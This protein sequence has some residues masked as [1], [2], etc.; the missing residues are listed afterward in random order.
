MYFFVAKI[1]IQI[2]ANIA[3]TIILCTSK[4]KNILAIGVAEL[5]QLW[6]ARFANRVINNADY[7][8][9]NIKDL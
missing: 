6:N 7:F 8:S 5:S 1:A 4:A 9:G 2:L 3:I